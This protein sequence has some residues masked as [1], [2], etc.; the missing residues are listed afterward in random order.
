MTVRAK[1]NCTHITDYGTQV[2][3]NMS[4]VYSSTGENKD[5]CEASPSGDLKISITKN[6]PA[7][8]M[9]EVGKSYYLDFTEA[10]NA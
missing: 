6:R 2:Q 9:F 8:T 5:F 10:P 3:V 4:A 1:F 7:A